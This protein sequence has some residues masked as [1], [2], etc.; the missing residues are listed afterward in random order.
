MPASPVVLVHGLGSSFEH[1]WVTPG[2]RDLLTESGRTVVAV[3]LPGHGRSPHTPQQEVA[4]LIED[5]ARRAGLVDA[6]GFSAGATALLV[7]AG[8]SPQRFSSIAVLGV[9]DGSVAANRPISPDWRRRF[10]AAL[11]SDS[12]PEPG[13]ALMI[14]R[15]AKSAGNDLRSVAAHVRSDQPAPQLSDLGKITARCL[16]VE[17]GADP[18]GPGEQLAQVIPDC[19]RV[20]LKGIDHYAIPNDVRCLDAVLAFLD[21]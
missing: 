16:L 10:A 11:E 12:E 14:R 21:E 5:E 13:M 19:R 18:A 20:V 8:R 6:V 3:E 1:N 4:A 7:A 17:G 2:W 9:G 15:L